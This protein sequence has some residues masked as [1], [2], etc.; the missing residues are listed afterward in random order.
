MLQ[1]PKTS[2]F[3]VS[4][5]VQSIIYHVDEASI[6]RALQSLARAVE[7]AV[8]HGHCTKVYL[9]YG[10][11]SKQRCLS[12]AAV[13]RLSAEFSGT[14]ELSY[15]FFD[16]NLG[17]ARG[18][19]RLSEN[20]DTD[21]LLILNPD[22]VVSPRLFENMLAPFSDEKTGMVEAK[23]LP[24]EHPKAYDP[25]SGETGW[26]TTACALTPTALFKA[27]EGF[28]ADTFFLY[29]D[30]VDYSWRVREAGYKV[31]FMPSAVVFHDKRVS[32]QGA[33][34]PSSAERRYSAEAGLLIAHKWSRPDLVERI[35]LTFRNGGPD[36][37]AAL[38]KFEEKKAAG[39]LPTPRDAANR[40][41]GFDG[42]FYTKHRY[43]L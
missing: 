13:E 20:A 31:I 16:E 6:R 5:Q 38:K 36:E 19:N 22:V 12:E 23:Q 25:I 24:I 39:T 27:I 26:A 40:I 32:K 7:L 34:Q 14:F 2:H 1:L 10:D 4:I 15:R 11:T 8:R 21:F 28:D 29:C 17:S 30:D 33:W 41:G 35:A 42:H 37:L 43:T 9:S 3:G 18:H